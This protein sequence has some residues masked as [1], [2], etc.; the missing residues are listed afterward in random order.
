MHYQVAQ[1]TTLNDALLTMKIKIH[2]LMDKLDKMFFQTC[3]V[4]VF[5]FLDLLYSNKWHLL[6]LLSASRDHMYV[7]IAR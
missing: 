2:I 1:W 4:F 3:N 5:D 6:T 7:H